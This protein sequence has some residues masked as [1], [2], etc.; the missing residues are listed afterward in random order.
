MTA[1]D[2]SV[3]SPSFLG[4]QLVQGILLLLESWVIGVLAPDKW[5][6]RTK[7]W[8]YVSVEEGRGGNAGY[9]ALQSRWLPASQVKSDTGPP[10]QG[11]QGETQERGRAPPMGR[12][13]AQQARA[14]T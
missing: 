4:K 13:Q 11:R 2:G 1:L 8:G 7:F 10:A 9:R 14:L 3:R 12:W 5:S 6:V